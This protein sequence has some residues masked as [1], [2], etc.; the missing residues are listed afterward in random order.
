[1]RRIKGIRFQILIS[2]YLE[3]NTD[4]Y[5]ILWCPANQGQ[6][7]IVVQ[8]STTPK[9]ISLRCQGAWDVNP[10]KLVNSLNKI[11]VIVIV[12]YTFD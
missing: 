5:I 10:A 12:K 3:K 2:T 4:P 11:Y 9:S 6:S 7:S 8:A 1:M